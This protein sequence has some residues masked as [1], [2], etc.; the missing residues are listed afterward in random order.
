VDVEFES[1]VEHY[2]PKGLTKSISNNLRAFRLMV[3]PSTIGIGAKVLI[4]NLISIIYLPFQLNILD[5]EPH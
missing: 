3:K 2:D 5:V 1:M 4:S